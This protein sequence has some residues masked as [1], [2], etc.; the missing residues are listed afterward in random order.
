M[1]TQAEIEILKEL[2]VE[3]I[4]IIVNNHLPK[5]YFQDGFGSQ[6]HQKLEQTKNT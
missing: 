2:I 6:L 3:E 1:Y 5:R 4:K